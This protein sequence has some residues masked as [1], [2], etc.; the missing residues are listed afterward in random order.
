MAAL[1]SELVEAL[2]ASVV[3]SLEQI[4]V[5]EV[6]GRYIGPILPISL[7]RLVVW[8]VSGQRFHQLGSQRRH[9]YV[10]ILAPLPQHIVKKCNGL[11]RG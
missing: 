6:V 10:K 3:F 2:G 9:A 5:D 11:M 8:A 1:A 4:R 7:E